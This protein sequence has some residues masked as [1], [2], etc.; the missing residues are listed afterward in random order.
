MANGPAPCT[1]KT[2]TCLHVCIY[3]TEDCTWASHL[4]SP[5]AIGFDSGVRNNMPRL[6]TA[7]AHASRRR[8]NEELILLY[9]VRLIDLDAAK[10]PYPKPN[11]TRKNYVCICR[12][13]PRYSIELS[14]GKEFF[15]LFSNG[16]DNGRVRV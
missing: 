16:P 6:V 8:F 3:T 15:I 4:P 9:S 7:D 14:D 13:L 2:N 10:S 1:G 12:F 5:Q 11:A